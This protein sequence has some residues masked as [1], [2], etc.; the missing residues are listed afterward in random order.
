MST[1]THRSPLS[2]LVLSTLAT[3]LVAGAASAATLT[4]PAAFPTIQDAIDAAVAGDTVL[5]SPGVYA[6]RIDF[7]GKDIVVKSTNPDDPTQTVIDAN[8]GGTAV[9]IEGGVG[10]STKLI[11][12]TIRD[13]DATSG[14]GLSIE[15]SPTIRDCVIRFSS[16]TSGGGAYVDGAPIFIDCDFIDNDA[17]SGGAVSVNGDAEF[18]SCR[19]LSNHATSGGALVVRGVVRIEDARFADNTATAASS[20]SLVEGRATI[21][22]STF[23]D[24]GETAIEASDEIIVANSL[25]S[26]GARALRTSSSQRPLVATVLNCTI[27]NQTLHA[28]DVLDGGNPTLL[29]VANSI[30]VGNTNSITLPPAGGAAEVVNVGRS[31]VEGGWPGVGN[32]DVD[33][34]FVDAA[35]GDFRLA[36]GSPCIDAGSN[37]LVPN[38]ISMDLDRAK[39]FV[40]DVAVL[41][42]GAGAGPVVDMGAYEAACEV[43]YVDADAVGGNNGSSWA[44]AYVDLQS[45]LD[46]A[47]TTPLDYILVAEGT[48]Q[49][50]RGTG[51]RTRAFTLVDGTK[52]IGG[53][54][55]IETDIS[56]REPLVHQ[57]VLSGA[58]GGSGTADNSYNVVVA[59]N[60]SSETALVGFIVQ[61]GNAD[62]AA[63]FLGMGGGILVVGGAPRIGEC[64]IRQNLS[65]NMGA[66]LFASNSD[67]VVERCRFNLN[68]ATN[69]GGA[70]AFS[71]GQPTVVNTLV[72]GNT[73]TG[74]GAVSFIANSFGTLINCTIAGNTATAAPCGGVYVAPPSSLFMR[75]AISWGN[76]GTAA[77]LEP[78][79]VSAPG[80]LDIGASNVQGW[81]GGLGGPLNTGLNPQFVL[82]FGVDGVA[83]NADDDYRLQTTSPALDSAIS[84]VLPPSQHPLDLDGKSRFVD[85]PFAFNAG[86]GPIAF[87][88]RGAYELNPPSCT[89]DLDGNQQVDAAD[90]AL[91]LG[92]W[93]GSG[94]ADL[95]GSG[96]V[97]AAD[98]AIMLGAFGGC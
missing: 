87:L 74:N 15:G 91:L 50:D 23:A 29:V 49:P 11:G 64:W 85:A 45:A 73:S 47:A 8:L 31:N 24:P 52:V 19:F 20:I 65:A 35:G 14:G 94:A 48:Y 22:R 41:D 30:L 62:G 76:S 86:V 16:A 82:P 4:V 27:V 25:F 77:G 54:A 18:E 58:I 26:A 34:G 53:F 80:F 39:R 92:A 61:K 90:L 37:L 75:N 13:G 68:E 36:E 10:R 2:T 51:D 56:E 40:N 17:T 7:L 5:V 96:T 67:V 46:E 88:D 72:H 83:G 97:D 81:T 6:E 70:M 42:T 3:T 95:D 66:G 57:T 79:Q 98:L 63:G 60:C 71:G 89:G 78:R 69:A 59:A 9:T 43:R 12:F 21:D 33:P 84:L 38:T 55:A 28:I 93:G 32:I 1:T 44:N